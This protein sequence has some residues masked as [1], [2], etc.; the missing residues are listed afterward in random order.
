MSESGYTM[1][2][3]SNMSNDI[4]LVNAGYDISSNPLYYK[5]KL[6]NPKLNV[7][8]YTYN[9]YDDSNHILETGLLCYGNFDRKITV[10]NTYEK[11]KIQYNG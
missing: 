5:F 4:I 8:E 2:L 7:G 11:E 3:T 10:N 1:V 9:L 6:L